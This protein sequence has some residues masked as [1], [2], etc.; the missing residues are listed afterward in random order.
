MSWQRGRKAASGLLMAALLFAS[1]DAD[2]RRHR[3]RSKDEAAEQADEVSADAQKKGRS[4][5]KSKTAPESPEAAPETAKVAA[6][7]AEDS[8]EKARLAAAAKARAERDWPTARRLLEESYRIS[9]SAEILFQ[10]GLLSEAEGRVVEAQDLMR[11]YLTDPTVEGAAD[12]TAPPAQPGPAQPQPQPPI[13]AQGAIEQAQRIINLPRQPSGEVSVQSERGTVVKVDDRVVGVLP[14]PLPLLL[15][16]GAHTITLEVA[17][18]NP[19]KKTVKVID[20]RGLELRINASLGAVLVSQ[21]PAVIPIV[22]LTGSLSTEMSRRLQLAAGQAVRRA[23]LSVFSTEVA[24]KSAAK[25]RSCLDRLECQVQLAKATQA[26][27]VLLLDAEVGGTAATGTPTWKLHTELIDAAVGDSAASSTETAT[28]SGSEQVLEVW[29]KMLD[30]VLGQGSVRTHGTLAVRTTPPGAIVRVGT[31]E[32]GRAPLER[33]VFSGPV[34][35]SVRLPDFA[36][37]RRT[38]TITEN[39]T[40]TVELTLKPRQFQTQIIYRQSPRPRWRLA[41]G[42][43]A[44][45][46]GLLLSGFGISGLVVN[47]QCG[48]EPLPGALACQQRFDTGTDGA[49]LLGVGLAATTAGVVLLALPGPRTELR[50]RQQAPED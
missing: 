23:S 9:A 34:E 6:G 48:A 46:A 33:P 47:G 35:L 11:R 4:K 39:Q 8:P 29:R 30:G 18:G 21:P 32:L 26:D 27:Y 12:A 17:A 41:L 16:V 50:V 38:L 36:T 14:L 3:S 43:S 44:V 49:I 22:S 13:A 45:G 1:V 25:L 42:G 10:L 15:P 40:S 37:E 2:A 19:P 5:R 24:L 31:R 7:S 20:G 28:Q